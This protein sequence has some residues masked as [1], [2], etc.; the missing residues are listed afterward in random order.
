M[1]TCLKYLLP[2]SCFL[3]LMVTLWPWALLKAFDRTTLIPGVQPLGQR[4]VQPI[5]HRVLPVPQEGDPVKKSVV[6]TGTAGA[7]ETGKGEHQ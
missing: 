5:P 3:L 7:N 4:L 1:I 2:I 6:Q